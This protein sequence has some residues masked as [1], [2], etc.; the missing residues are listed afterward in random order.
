[1]QT[2]TERVL[3][4]SSRQVK[5]LTLKEAKA[6]IPAGASEVVLYGFYFANGRTT[7]HTYIKDVNSY[8]LKCDKAARIHKSS[9]RGAG[10]IASSIPF[11][12]TRFVFFTDKEHAEKFIEYTRERLLL[13]IEESQETSQKNLDY[14]AN[15]TLP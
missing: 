2:L 15:V 10:F 13:F 12:S 6:L 3:A 9:S 8:L 14:L 7:S 1:M 11:D 5:P 4:L